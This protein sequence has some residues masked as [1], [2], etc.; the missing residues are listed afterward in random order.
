M[1]YVWKRFPLQVFVA[2]QMYSISEAESLLL[3]RD[4]H[5]ERHRLITSPREYFYRNLMLR[6]LIAPLLLQALQ[7]LFV[8]SLWTYV[9]Q[10]VDILFIHLYL[11]PPTSLLQSIREVFFPVVNLWTV[12]GSA[13]LSAG[14]SWQ[15]VRALHIPPPIYH[16]REQKLKDFMKSVSFSGTWILIY[17]SILLCRPDLNQVEEA[18]IEQDLN[19]TLVDGGSMID[20]KPI[21]FTELLLRILLSAV[22]VGLQMANSYALSEK[23]ELGTECSDKK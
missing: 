3:I 22:V 15:Y 11:T 17:A 16:N 23:L 20:E 14:A 6:K 19:A 9:A 21:Y 13:F 18:T 7:T 12:L 8:V 2:V 4:A 1:V 10:F 5:R